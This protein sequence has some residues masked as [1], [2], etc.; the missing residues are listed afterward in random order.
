MSSDEPLR[1][2][3]CGCEF[4]VDHTI[5]CMKHFYALDDDRLLTVEWEDGNAEPPF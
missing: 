3:A 5:F 1:L 2:L 4:H